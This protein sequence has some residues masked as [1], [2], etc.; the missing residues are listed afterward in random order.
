MGSTKTRLAEPDK[1][2]WRKVAATA[3]P[4]DRM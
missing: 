2:M 1:T 3:G 4:G